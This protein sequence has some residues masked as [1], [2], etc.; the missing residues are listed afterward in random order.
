MSVGFPAPNSLPPPLL[1]VVRVVGLFKAKAKTHST[2]RF[3]VIKLK[4]NIST[5]VLEGLEA[6]GPNKL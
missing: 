2:F 4:L 5:R 1:V 6:Q 3:G